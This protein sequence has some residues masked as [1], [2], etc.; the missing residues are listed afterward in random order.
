MQQSAVEHCHSS[1]SH[2]ADYQQGILVFHGFHFIDLNLRPMMHSMMT[3]V[4]NES[5]VLQVEVLSVLYSC[6]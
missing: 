5:L 2:F 4:N 1:C 3:S 6:K